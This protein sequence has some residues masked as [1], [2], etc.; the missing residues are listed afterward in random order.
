[1]KLGQQPRKWLEKKAKRGFRGYPIGTIAFYGP[2]ER[3]ASKVAV[4]VVRAPQSAPAELHRWFSEAGDLRM[5][6]T[7]LAEIVAFLREYEVHSVA[8]TNGIIGCPH[9]EGIDYPEGDNC[10]N[11]P[12]WAGRDRAR[13]ELTP[14]RLCLWGSVGALSR[15]Y[16]THRRRALSNDVHVAKC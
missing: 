4:S 9:E 16:G 1:M 3:C 11:C 12:Y 14:C 10:P 7:I 5:D 8:M 2:D 6:G 13:G 15:R